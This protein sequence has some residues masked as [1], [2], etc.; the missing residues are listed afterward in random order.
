MERLVGRLKVP[1]VLK[2]VTVFSPMS[3]LLAVKAETRRFVLFVY[4]PPLVG[5]RK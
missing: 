3:W 4:A 5:V 1:G 2:L